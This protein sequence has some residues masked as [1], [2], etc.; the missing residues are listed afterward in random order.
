MHK[1]M[2]LNK[3][4]FP[5]VKPVPRKMITN[6]SNI[7]AEWFDRQVAHTTSHMSDG[8]VNDSHKNL[9]PYIISG[10]YIRLFRFS[11]FWRHVHW[12]SHQRFGVACSLYLHGLSNHLLALCVPEDEGTKLILKTRNYLSIY[13]SSCPEDFSFHRC[14]CDSLFSW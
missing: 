13:K 9:K 3:E 7:R 4:I 5:V 1:Q 6:F 10:D 12:K 11:G 8:L 2:S 14:R